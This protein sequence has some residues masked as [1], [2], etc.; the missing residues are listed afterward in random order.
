MLGD[1]DQAYEYYRQILPLARTDADLYRAEP[2][3]YPQN[4]CGPAHPAV[5]HGPQ[6]LAD[7][8]GGLDL[9]R[10]RPSGSWASGR[11]SRPA[12]APAIP[13]AWPGFTARRE[14]RGT[15]YEITVR[16]EGPGNAVS[17][18]VDGRPVPGDVVPLPSPG[19]E[20]VVVEVQ[21]G[22]YGRHGVPRCP[23]PATP[24]MPWLCFGVR[25]CPLPPHHH[26]PAG[27]G[28]HGLAL[29]ARPRRLGRLP[30]GRR[31]GVG[32]ARDLPPERLPDG[33]PRSAGGLR[34]HHPLRRRARLS[35]GRGLGITREHLGWWRAMAA[36]PAGAL[37]HW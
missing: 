33:G 8:D 16:R 1:G 5:R 27:D 15:G 37:R 34:A 30:D 14:F 3:V 18:S 29:R 24:W 22:A 23:A 26:P 20:R 2:Y 25:R 4:I 35:P 32:P 19:T 36:A 28:G 12:V 21:L 17:L 10:R 9:R 6:R 11:P 13:A 31:P 7:R